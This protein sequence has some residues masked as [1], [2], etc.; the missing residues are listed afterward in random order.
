MFEKLLKIFSNKNN[1]EIKQD[2]KMSIK[3]TKDLEKNK[4]EIASILGKS[5]DIVIRSLEVSKYK[6]ALCYVNGMVNGELI[7][8]D[9]IRP[10]MVDL[11]SRKKT[12]PQNTFEDLKENILCVADIKEKTEIKDLLDAILCGEAVLL[13]D[14]M[15]YA[16]IINTQEFK[17]RTIQEPNTE[18]IVR[19]SREGFTENL[20]INTSMIRRRVKNPNLVIKLMTMGV[21]TNTTVAIA[22]IDNIAN[23]KIVKEVKKRLERVKNKADTILESGYIEQYIEDNPNSIFPTIGNSERPDA[24]AA[25]L[26]QGKIAIICDGTPFVLLVPYL[27]IENF[28]S[29]DDYFS[30]SLIS[31]LLRSLRLISYVITI[32]LPALYIAV[33]TFHYEMIPTVLLITMA[34]SREGIPLPSFLEAIFMVIVFEIIREGGTRMPR[35]VGQAISIVGALVLGQAA[36]DAGI[37]SSPMIIIVAITGITSF[38]NPSL[39]Y[40]SIILRFVFMLLATWLGLYGVLIGFFFVLAHMCSLRSFGSPYFSPFAPMNPKDLKDTIYRSSIWSLSNRPKAI[41]WGKNYKK[42]SYGLKPKTPPPR[43]KGRN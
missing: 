27:F 31:T 23:D 4:E 19:G 28:Q 9:I 17:T 35:Q 2:N 26:I 11:G 14:G 12:S 37:V 5:D 10:I 42:Q 39:V 18:T 34:A 13:V 7:N 38:V 29:N 24:V 43:K 36:V 3:L 25:K 1:N 21:Q 15:E 6:F 22:Y 33:T 41:T 32:S 40:I 20:Q 8:Q 30:G 16:I